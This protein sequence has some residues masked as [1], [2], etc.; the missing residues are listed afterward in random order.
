MKTIKLVSKENIKKF[1]FWTCKWENDHDTVKVEQPNWD[2]C[3]LCWKALIS[4]LFYNELRNE[5][6]YREKG[7]NN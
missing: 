2:Y 7:T 3:P 6:I 5:K 1:L 4:P